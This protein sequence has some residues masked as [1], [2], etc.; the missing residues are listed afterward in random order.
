MKKLRI[1]RDGYILISIAFYIAAVIYMLVL[2]LQPQVVC[3]VSGVVLIAYGI[4]KIIGFF[5]KDPYCLAFQYDLAMGTLLILLG[6]AVLFFNTRIAVHLPIGLGWLAL[7]DS[8]LKI[9]MSK[10]AKEFG[11]EKW[12]AIL[13]IALVTA[14]LSLLLIFKRFSKPRAAHII[15]GCALFAEGL[16]NHCTVHYTVRRMKTSDPD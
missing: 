11:L 12:N 14:V 13:G 10:D 9:Q 7:L 6:A 15:V 16:M 1:A 5:S 8:L 4:I 2:G 3:L